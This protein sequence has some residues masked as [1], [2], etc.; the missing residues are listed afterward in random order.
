LFLNFNDDLGAI[1]LQL[2]SVSWA[3]GDSRSSAVALGGGAQLPT[4]APEPSTWAM[5]L[6]G[7][8]GLGYAAIRRRNARGALA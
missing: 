2:T 3:G 4:A 8:A 6:L 7:F 1:H 5:M